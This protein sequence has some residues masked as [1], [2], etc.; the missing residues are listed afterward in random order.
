MKTRFLTSLIILTI[1]TVPALA[2]MGTQQG[3]IAGGGTITDAGPTHVINK[4]PKGLGKPRVP[5]HQI[6]FVASRSDYDD[7]IVMVLDINGNLFYYH[8]SGNPHLNPKATMIEMVTTVPQ[9][10]VVLAFGVLSAGGFVDFPTEFPAGGQYKD[11][12]DIWMTLQSPQSTNTV[13]A[14]ANALVSPEFNA[15][16]SVFEA[17]AQSIENR[18]IFEMEVFAPNG[19]RLG[20]ISLQADG[21]AVVRKSSNNPNVATTI[22]AEKHLPHARMTIIKHAMQQADFFNA[23]TCNDAAGKNTMGSPHEYEVTYTHGSNT[24]TVRFGDGSDLGDELSGLTSWVL[25]LV[26]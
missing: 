26:D 1:L 20:S 16:R 6:E 8:Q 25:N 4:N 10:T 11:A 23:P 5:E 7:N 18:V 22:V 17:L 12:F 15:V 9:E 13:F 14:A 21:D 3:P 19:T 2:Q 24:R